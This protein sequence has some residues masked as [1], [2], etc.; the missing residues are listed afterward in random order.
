MFVAKIYLEGTSKPIIRD[1]YKTSQN[2]DANYDAA[3]AEARKIFNDGYICFP[4]GKKTICIS[5]SEV[6]KIEIERRDN[7]KET[8]T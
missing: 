7:V 2:E 4:K 5:S 1:A 3:M 8:T 6:K